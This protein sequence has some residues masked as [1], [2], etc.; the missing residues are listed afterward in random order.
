M[1]GAASGFGWDCLRLVRRTGPSLPRALRSCPPYP[2]GPIAVRH[3]INT[4]VVIS[5]EG[6]PVHVNTQ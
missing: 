4:S 3:L 2:Y 6:Q 1:V 5:S